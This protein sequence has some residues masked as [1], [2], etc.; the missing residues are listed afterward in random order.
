MRLGGK[1][2]NMYKIVTKNAV[3]M[4]G[5]WDEILE[6]LSKLGNGNLT[7]REILERGELCM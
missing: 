1:G 7:I 5:T 6:C 2:K 4:K 3:V